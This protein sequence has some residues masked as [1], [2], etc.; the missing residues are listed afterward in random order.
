M[1]MWMEEEVGALKSWPDGLWYFLHWSS[2]SYG[3]GIDGL[4]GADEDE[5]MAVFV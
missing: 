3:V 1:C 5:A 4:S 2:L